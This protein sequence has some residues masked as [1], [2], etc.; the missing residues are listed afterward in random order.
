MQC[1][2]GHAAHAATAGHQLHHH[3]CQFR[4]ADLGRF[5]VGG[6]EEAG[7]D[8]QPVPFHRVGDQGFREQVFGDD[9]G[10][11]G[12]AVLV[13][14]REHRFISEQRYIGDPGQV[15]RIG[16]H[17]QVQIATGQGRQRGEGKPRGQVQLDFRPGVAEL[18]D[19]RH[20]PL[21]ATVALDG[22]VQTTGGATGQATDVAFG[23]AQQR[24]GG[25]GQLQQAQTGA[26]EAHRFGLAHEQRHA[27]ALLQLLELVGQ[28]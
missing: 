7:E 27:H 16:G 23:G 6:F 25:V 8:V 24:Q 3:H 20:Q 26:G 11:A 4:G 5:D 19:G 2:M 10:L 28:G 17:H 22:H 14:H 21:E 9:I 18:V 15:H 1:P 12:Q 13:G